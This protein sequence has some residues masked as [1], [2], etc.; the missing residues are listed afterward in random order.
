[1]TESTLDSQVIYKLATI[2]T[3]VSE[4]INQLSG[5]VTR[6][7]NRIN[8]DR[9]EVEKALAATKLDIEQERLKLEKRVEVNEKLLVTLNKW[10]EAW[11]V[12][13][14]WTLGGLSLAWLFIGEPIQ[15]KIGVFLH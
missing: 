9:L 3:K 11:V 13:T 4:V 15:Q 12:R 7:E 2:E 8:T 1:M 10:K 6:L 5:I 14:T